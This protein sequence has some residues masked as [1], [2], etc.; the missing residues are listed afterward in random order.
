MPAKGGKA[1]ASGS[2]GCVFRPS[3]KCKDGTINSGVSKLME[4]DDANAEM[5]EMEPILKIVRNIPDSEKFF[6]ANNIS[7]CSPAPLSESDKEDFNEKCKLF[8]DANISSANVNSRLSDLSIINMPDLGIDLHGFIGTRI[9][10]DEELKKF[11]TMMIELLLNGVVPMNRSKI[12]HHDLKDSNIMVDSSDNTIIIDWG[13]AGII[14]DGR[15]PDNIMERPIQYNTPFSSM[16]INREFLT[17][18]KK[19]CEKAGNKKLTANQNL[20]FLKAFFENHMRKRPGHEVYFNSVMKKVFTTTTFSKMFLL[21]NEEV[22]QQFTDGCTFNIK[23]YFNEVYLYNVDVWGLCTA[24]LQFLYHDELL[25]NISASLKKKTK[26]NYYAI[27]EICFTNGNKVIDV[28]KI[29]ILLSEI[30]LP[31]TLVATRSARKAEISPKPDPTLK[32]DVPRRGD[33]SI[34]PNESSENANRSMDANANRSMDANANRSMDANANRSMDANASESPRQ[35]QSRT[36]RK[37]RCPNGYRRHPK[38]KRCTIMSGPNKG[39]T[40]DTPL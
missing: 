12:I 16:L 29:V 27:L 23:K 14:R 40:I 26:E 24:F 35:Q 31:R 6:A 15:I 1:I 10:G 22:V 11:N 37:K 8:S 19:A 34:K 38:T 36:R 30:A 5:D 39:K 28:D 13:F 7:M 3:L 18:Y 33:V 20:L 21:Y 32:P 2:Y 25:K 9:T 4:N 17:E